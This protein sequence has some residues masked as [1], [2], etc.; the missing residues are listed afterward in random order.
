MSTKRGCRLGASELQ[1]VLARC[2]SR[3][4][5][6]VDQLHELTLQEA[7][8]QRLFDFLEE[9]KQLSDKDLAAEVG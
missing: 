7:K 8:I 9:P 6:G 5:P 3:C 1:L 2:C 4:I